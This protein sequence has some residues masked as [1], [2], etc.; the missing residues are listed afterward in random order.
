MVDADIKL[1][2]DQIDGRLAARILS[3]E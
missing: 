3:P 1:L 2:A